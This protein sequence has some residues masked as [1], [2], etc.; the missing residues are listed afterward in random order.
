MTTWLQG[1][2]E[3][4][5]EKVMSNLITAPL[6]LGS[7][8]RAIEVVRPRQRQ[9]ALPRALVPGL[10]QRATGLIAFIAFAPLVLAAVTAVLVVLIAKLLF[11]LVTVG[12]ER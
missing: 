5:E 8:D 3:H 12:F 6:S 10:V 4:D 9:R 7:V 11:A 1:A 2:L